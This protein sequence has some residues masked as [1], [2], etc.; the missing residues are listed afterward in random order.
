MKKNEKAYMAVYAKEWHFV[1]RGDEGKFIKLPNTECY[2]L[3]ILIRIFT[4]HLECLPLTEHPFAKT[5]EVKR[6]L[7]TTQVVRITP[8]DGFWE[9][10]TKSGTIYRLIK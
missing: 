10:V 8:R 7:R 9:V 2:R 4:V 3:K 5:D 1:M 6:G